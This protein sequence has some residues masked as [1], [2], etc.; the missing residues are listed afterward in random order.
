MVHRLS[1]EL[2]DSFFLVVVWSFQHVFIIVQL[3]YMSC[4]ICTFE[5]KLE[6]IYYK[7]FLVEHKN[8]NTLDYFQKKRGGGSEVLW[9]AALLIFGLMNTNINWTTDKRCITVLCFIVL[10]SVQVQDMSTYI[11]WS[12]TK[13][14]TKYW[15]FV[16]SSCNGV[17]F[18]LAVHWERLVMLPYKRPY[19]E[20]D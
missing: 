11:E 17:D 16:Y 4:D 20:K 8:F 5:I 1:L 12:D 6:A 19:I 18:M 9:V 3:L 13:S 10:V 2:Y 7:W 14:W 15:C